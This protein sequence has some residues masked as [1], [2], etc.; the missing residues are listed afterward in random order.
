MLY[1]LPQEELYSVYL[2]QL[3][4]LYQ[5]F[6]SAP[7]QFKQLYI[8]LPTSQA[9]QKEMDITDVK[10]EEYYY[11]DSEEERLSTISQNVCC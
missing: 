11:S 10:D 9:F 7:Q 4:Q 3:K 5:L 8:M 6:S 1:Q 2:K